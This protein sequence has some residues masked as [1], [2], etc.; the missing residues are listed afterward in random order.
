[1]HS[2]ITQTRNIVVDTGEELSPT[3]NSRLSE[4]LLQAPC[5]PWSKGAVER[6]FQH[7]NFA[8]IIRAEFLN[9]PPGR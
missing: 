3:Q 8:E 4:K 7:Q 5:R 1:M 6:Q 2:K 9:T